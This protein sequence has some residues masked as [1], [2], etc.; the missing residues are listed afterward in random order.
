VVAKKWGNDVQNGRNRTCPFGRFLCTY[1]S[2]CPRLEAR[3]IFLSRECIVR[4]YKVSCFVHITLSSFP[5][6]LTSSAV[7]LDSFCL[8]K[9]R[10]P[11]EACMQSKDRFVRQQESKVKRTC[12]QE[13][14]DL[15]VF[16][17]TRLSV[18]VFS[19]YRQSFSRNDCYLPR[20]SQPASSYCIV[21]LM[22]GCM[23]ARASQERSSWKG[24]ARVGW[25]FVW[26]LH[27]NNPAWG[28]KIFDEFL[29]NSAFAPVPTKTSEA[30]ALIS[31]ALSCTPN[32]RPWLGEFD[33]LLKRLQCQHAFHQS[34][35]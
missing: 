3:L 1:I 9:A 13:S 35:L 2:T 18:L 29:S 21:L 27:V 19:S 12:H 30:V 26:I 8:Q 14:A 4:I 33:G 32:R 5:V 6:L 17:W 31:L 34:S 16:N 15:E 28:V 25:L 22:H 11:D 7:F 20:S 10:V 23:R 24:W